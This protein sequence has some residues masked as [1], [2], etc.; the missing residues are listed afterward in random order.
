LLGK[1]IVIAII[2]L[3]QLLEFH[4]YN[5]NDKNQKWRSNHNE[6]V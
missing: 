1:R 5:N 6:N 3:T 2:A 4:F